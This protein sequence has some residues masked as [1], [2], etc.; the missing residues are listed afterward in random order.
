M[1]LVNAG[2]QRGLGAAG[3]TAQ[4][5]WSSSGGL[6]LLSLAFQ[7]FFPFSSH[8]TFILLKRLLSQLHPPKA[9]GCGAELGCAHRGRLDRPGLTVTHG[10]RQGCPL[11]PVGMGTGLSLSAVGT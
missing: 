3:Q 10:H 2:E 9:D 7:P 1:K 11:G 6:H 4:L 8:L 5:P